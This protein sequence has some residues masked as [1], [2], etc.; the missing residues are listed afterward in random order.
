MLHASFQM[1]GVQ[2]TLAPYSVGGQG[3]RAG[4]RSGGAVQTGAELRLLLTAALD[5]ATG[6]VEGG[7]RKNLDRC[8]KRILAAGDAEKLPENGDHSKHDLLL[9]ENALANVLLWYGSQ[10][11]TQSLLLAARS[12]AP[13]II[14][15][16]RG[17]DS[18]SFEDS[19]NAAVSEDPVRAADRVASVARGSTTDH[20]LFRARLLAQLVPAARISLAVVKDPWPRANALWKRLWDE[21]SPAHDLEEFLEGFASFLKQTP[22]LLHAIVMLP[23]SS[24]ALKDISTTWVNT[25]VLPELS[26]FCAHTRDV[27]SLRDYE[28]LR[29]FGATIRISDVCLNPLPD[30]SGTASQ[31]LASMYK[32]LPK[33][34]KVRAHLLQWSLLESGNNQYYLVAYSMT[35]NIPGLGRRGDGRRRRHGESLRAPPMD[36]QHRWDLARGHQHDRGHQNLPQVQRRRRRRRRREDRDCAQHPNRLTLPRHQRYDHPARRDVLWERPLPRGFSAL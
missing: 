18:R 12:Y 22:G 34:E 13:I 36:G 17:T 2:R 1:Q 26:T 4:L 35:Y 7:Q 29:K 32:N 5:Y 19:L 28:R 30:S 8:S 20:N 25:M 33:I 3:L 23:A 9:G 21:F 27:L 16:G 6:T 24:D 15:E 10:E 31:T 14:S 11:V